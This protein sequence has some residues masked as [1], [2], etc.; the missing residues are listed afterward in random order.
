M[1][2]EKQENTGNEQFVSLVEAKENI[3]GVLKKVEKYG[4]VVIIKDKKPKYVIQKIE[5]GAFL[6]L[7]D[8]EK[9]EIISNRI[10]KKHQ[11]AF[12]VLSK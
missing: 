8:E 11:Y 12:E 1:A 10:L 9:I 5:N 2:N 6:I 7:T 3:S 4:H